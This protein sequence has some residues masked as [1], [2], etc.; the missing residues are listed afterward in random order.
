MRRAARLAL[1][2]A[3]L[4]LLAATGAA[5]ALAATRFDTSGR[6][7]VDD[8]GRVVVLHGV[9]L[10]VKDPAYGFRPARIGFDA[11]D[12][13]LLASHGLNVVRLGVAWK[14]LEPTAGTYDEDYLTSIRDTVSTLAAGGIATLLDMHQDMY[15]SRFQGGLMPDW[16]VVG[17]AAT[18]P[19]VPQ[20]GFPVNYVFQDALN[21]AYSAFWDNT[22]V[23]AT[24]S[25][26]Q[27]H[28]AAAWA[29]VAER[30]KDLPSLLGY[31]LLNEPWPGG[32]PRECMHA[33]RLKTP[34]GCGI[35]QFEATALTA[36]SRRMTAGIRAADPDGIVWPAPLLTFD[37]GTAS[38]LGAVEQPAGFAFNAYCPKPPANTV[39]FLFA[40]TWSCATAARRTFH[41]ADAVSR[42]N[43]QP[44]FMTEFG[45]SHRLADIRDYVAQADRRAIS[46]SYWAYT[47]GGVPSLPG[48]DDAIVRDPRKPLTGTNVPQRMLGFLTR[49]YL[50][51]TS[52]TP[53]GWT[54]SSRAR[55]FRA[56]Y[57][58]SRA[59]GN[60]AFPIGSVTTVEA[61]H[62]VYPRGYR[63][64]V[65]GARV[66]SAAGARQ[67]R[68]ALCPGARQVTLTV[69]P[70]RTGPAA[71]RCPTPR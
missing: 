35:P 14:A 23:P 7:I 68:L 50:S 19:A 18:E 70:G 11:D 30:L 22:A 33:G 44:L 16:A 62:A 46:W 41:H 51:L 66:V 3:V 5:P 43:G 42:R 39:V 8:R 20:L 28:L 52:G 36:F 24:G 60:G 17:P 55:A 61:P 45:A 38:G 29:H 25:G 49:P 34:S 13:R 69:A 40:R 6:W 54:Y 59:D 31:N 47:A 10:V 12:A 71:R 15:A 56:A 53:D 64:D 2:G 58:P 9:N 48:G 32:A 26:V 21:H 27:D 63:V 67:L 65:E 37:S 1:T 57:R 4:A